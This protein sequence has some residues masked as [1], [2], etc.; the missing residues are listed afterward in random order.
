M[1]CSEVMSSV[2]PSTLKRETTC[3]F[4]E[5]GSCEYVR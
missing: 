5:S 4:E 1:R 2:L 3:V